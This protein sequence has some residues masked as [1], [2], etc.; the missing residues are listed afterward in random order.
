MLKSST[1][2]P[3]LPLADELHAVLMG[4]PNLVPRALRIRQHSLI[5]V[6]PTC[7][8]MSCTLSTQN[9]KGSHAACS[10]CSGAQPRVSVTRAAMTRAM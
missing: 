7:R 4:R 6:R 10:S 5:P 9:S 3:G 8:L 2:Y 1:A